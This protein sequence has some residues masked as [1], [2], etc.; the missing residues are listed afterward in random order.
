[1]VCFIYM[2]EEL[3]KAIKERISAEQTKEEIIQAVL[4]MGHTAEVAEAAYTLAAHDQTFTK[5]APLRFSARALFKGGWQFVKKHPRLTAVSA[6]PLVAEVFLTAARNSELGTIGGYPAA[7]ALIVASVI[8]ALAYV[9]LLMVI[10]MRLTKPDIPLTPTTALVFIRQH[11]L[12]LCVIYFF[13]GLMILGGLALF[14]LPGLAVMISI[15]FAQYVYIHEGKRGLLALLGSSALV[16]G[17]FWHLL[18]KILA[19]IFLSFLPMLALTIVFAIIDGIYESTATTLIGEAVLQV[20][21]AALTV[22][23]LY[24]MNSVY[25]KL[26]EHDLNLPGKLFPK[27]R[28]IF[29][30]I[31]GVAAVAAIG[32]MVVFAESL[33]FLDELP[34]I[35]TPSGVQAQ[36]SATSL[37]A[38]RYW[39]DNNQSYMSVCE[40]LRNSVTESNEVVCNDNGEAWALSATDTDGTLWCADKNTLAKQIQVPLEDRTECFA[41]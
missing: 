41:L 28:Y 36:V 13:S 7:A 40:S 16:R 18:N 2:T 9:A 31:A 6:I 33:D 8:A 25:L 21:T 10:L 12:S 24:A 20:V 11:V 37:I 27:A 19:F 17:R 30:M 5:D 34:V 26:K 32:L 14:L 1:M 38:N 15:T 4:A 29:L 23:N 3:I 39:L 35:E 22:I